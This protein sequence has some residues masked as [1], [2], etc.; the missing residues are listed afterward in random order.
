MDSTENII[1]E[2]NSVS[3]ERLPPIQPRWKKHISLIVCFGVVIVSMGIY[4]IKT[5]DIIKEHKEMLE[6]KDK[7]IVYLTKEN[8]NLRNQSQDQTK[9][10]K[11]Q[12]QE[13][14]KKQQDLA[15]QNTKLTEENTKLR[16]LL[17]QWKVYYDSIKN[18]IK[19]VETNVKKDPVKKVDPKIKK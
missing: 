4:V 18:R 6:N 9:I 15:V 14:N 19:P 13:V 5:Q 1:I 7:S 3:A 11:T 10:L 2:T 8:E 12:I 16:D 17:K